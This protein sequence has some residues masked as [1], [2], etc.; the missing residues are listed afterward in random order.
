MNYMKKIYLFLITAACTAGLFSACRKADPVIR[1]EQSTLSDIYVTTVGKGGDR[2][3]DAR[4]SPNNDTIYFD[5]PWYFPPDFDKEVDITK[6]ILRATIPTDATMS[7]TLGN[8]VDLSKPL[9][10]TV[11]AGNGAQSK[12]V[13]VAKKVGDVS[14]TSARIE[15]TT[16]GT[17]EAVDGVV[18]ANE[19]LFYVLP[20]TDV[21]NATLTYEINK[22]S[23]ASVTYGAS[24]NLS[25]N[26]PFTV[27]GID[28]KAKTYTLRAV[29][30]VKLAYGAGINRKLWTKAGAELG[31]TANNE[32]CLAVSGDNLVLTRR[33]TPAKFSVFNRFTGAY[34]KD[35]YN[36]FTA[37]NFQVI[38]DTADHILACSW[39]P[40]NSKFTLYRYNDVDDAAPA[41]LVEWTNNN[42][43]AIT[44]DGG[45]GRRVN[46]YG[47]LTKDA[48]IMAPAGQSAV[49][50]KWRIVNGA[51]VSQ[52][53]EV[54]T[55]KSVTGGSSVFMGYYAEAQPIG[56][57]ANADYFIN[58][59]F[60]VALV[61]GTTHE[62]MAALTLP[63]P[64]VFTMPTAYNRFNNANYLSI[65]KYI[66]SYDLNQ[67]QIALFDVT[68][69]SMMGLPPTDPNYSALNVFTSPTFT[70][71]ANG[72]GTADI[73]VGYSNNRER[74]QVYMLL[75]NGGIMAH[76]F[77]NY[78]P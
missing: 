68:K 41:K 6:L 57:S 11:T 25:Q 9:E 69:T 52:T 30:P 3:F 48:V 59:Q 73:A 40:K 51:A 22:H 1:K 37:T 62:R 75:T 14:V 20:G 58:Y 54:I 47:D 44:G 49:I 60:E 28:N 35:M 66:N 65:V 32:V 70:G 43:A 64:V 31:F 4:Y 74:M 72:N 77:T 5:I 71:T 2:L 78:A 10:I 55:Y 26:V 36:P 29:E 34:I 18:Q 42:P 39:A 38:S 76:E 7:P 8:V 12:Y 27:T 50:Y 46:V 56:T 23:K 16:G 13:I 33:T 45:V 67:V 15:F 24:V 63:Y 53:P 21:S 19:I 61:N 17:T